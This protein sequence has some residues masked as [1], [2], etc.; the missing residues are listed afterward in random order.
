MCVGVC[1]LVNIG[2][3][4]CIIVVIGVSDDEIS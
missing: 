4:D 1:I 2:G 3:V